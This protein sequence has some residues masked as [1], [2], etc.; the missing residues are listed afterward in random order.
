M[1][2]T[3]AP[4][5]FK[6]KFDVVSCFI[7]H[8][9]KF[10]LLHRQDHKP[11]GDTW[12][13]PAGKV[14]DGEDLKSAIQREIQEEVGLSINKMELIFFKSYFVRY[15]EYDFVYHIFSVTLDLVPELKLDTREHKDIKWVTPIEALGMN[16][17]Q[18]E[19]F[20]VKNFYS[21]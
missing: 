18:D 4:K 17:I 12:G 15:A 14:D 7:Q 10:L 11:Q 16:L 21:I 1:I 19:D 20:C 6:K 5:D 9:R 2:T 13:V 8:D 3:T